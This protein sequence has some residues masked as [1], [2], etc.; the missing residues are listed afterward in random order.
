MDVF[1]YEN[2]KDGWFV[3]DFEPTA[4]KTK[5]FEVCYKK[6]F[7]D[8]KWETHY[9]KVGT[10]INLLLSGSMLIQGKKLVSGDVFVLHPYEIADPIFLED[11]FL[12]IIKNVS[13]VK[14]KFVVA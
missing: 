7:K 3:G 11:C 13:G 4:Y 2:F 10:E 14:D 8:E 6:H 1:R 5:N 12:V 9:H